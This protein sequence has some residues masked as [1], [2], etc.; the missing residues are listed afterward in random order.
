[1][2]R[3]MTRRDLVKAGVMGAMALGVGR[4]L[5]SMSNAAFGATGPDSSGLAGWKPGDP[6]GYI[7]PNIG[8]FQLRSFKCERYEVTVPDTLDLAERATVAVNG[9]TETTYEPANYE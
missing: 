4:S 7:N 3:E 1:M 2:R 9:L 6:I 8:N 5:G